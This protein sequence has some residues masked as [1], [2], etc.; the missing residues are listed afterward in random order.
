MMILYVEDTAESLKQT[1][2]PVSPCQQIRTGRSLNA[3]MR[4]GQHRSRQS[5][6]SGTA[7]QQKSSKKPTAAIFNLLEVVLD[8][9]FYV[10]QALDAVLRQRPH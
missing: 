2:S 3:A 8:L 1:A 5:F 4:L 9:L 10:I 7:P 6:V